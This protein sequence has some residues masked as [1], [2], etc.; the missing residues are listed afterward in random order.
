[1]SPKVPVVD[2]F[3]GPGGLGEGFAA[4]A[5]QTAFRIALSI[6]KDEVA[7]RTLELRAFFRQFSR[8][9]VPDDYYDHLR[10][11]K[12]VPRHDLFTLHP[13]AAAA[14]QCEAWNA[15]LGVVDD[16]EVDRRIHDA[17]GNASQWVL[18][19]GPPCQAYSIVGRARRGGIDPADPNVKLYR[20]YLRIL[21]RHAPPVFVMENVKGLLSAKLDGESIFRTMLDDLT[22][23]ERRI[24]AS[25]Q[26]GVKYRILSLVTSDENLLGE[27]PADPRGYVIPCEKYGV[28]QARQRVILL[29]VRSDLPI[30]SPHTLTP[31]AP[32]SVLQVLDGLPRLRSGISKQQDS[33]SDWLDL[34]R[35]ATDSEWFLELQDQNGSTLAS[36]LSHTVQNLRRP[37]K[38]RGDEFVD[39]TAKCDYRP[40]W[41]LDKRLE[42]VCNHSTRSHIA[43]DMHRYLFGAVYAQLHKTSPTLREFPASLLPNHTNAKTSVKGGHFADRFRVQLSHRPSTTITSHIS[44]DGHYYIHYDPSQSRSLTVREDARLQTL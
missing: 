8:A 37:Q 11:P 2:L 23:P 20:Q 39:R 15:V 36:R 10:D 13:K 19:G 7:H 9:D 43:S 42:G 18:I 17:I 41:F 27:A 21:A 40:D 38:D 3:A 28:P 5:E 25:K 29:G 1:M 33:A 26:G 24:N 31:T 16:G 44:K 32:I 12:S 14:A 34:L 6:E 30:T 35:S 22:L 4:L